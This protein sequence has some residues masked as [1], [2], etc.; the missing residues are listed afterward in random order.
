MQLTDEFYPL[1]QAHGNT[2]ELNVPQDLTVE[3]D[4][5]KLARVFNNLLKNAA[6]Y[7]D[8][9]TEVTVSAEAGKEAVSVRVTSTGKTIPAD[10]LDALFEKFYRLDDARTSHTGG[11]GLGLAIA[12]EIVTLHGGTILAESENGQTTFMVRL[13]IREKS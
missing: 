6:A 11:S 4:A 5:G 3:G 13:P 12:K 10:K 2:I 1:L 7:S 8:P 9:G